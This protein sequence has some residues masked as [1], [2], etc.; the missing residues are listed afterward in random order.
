MSV[1]QTITFKERVDAFWHW[2]IEHADEMGQHIEAGMAGESSAEIESKISASFT[3][4]IDR[5]LPGFNYIFGSHPRGGYSFTLSP[6]GN[7]DLR[8]LAEY[9]L[10]QAPTIE[11][12]TFYSSRQPSLD[13]DFG[14]EIAGV[15]FDS[16]VAQF[17]LEVNEENEVIDAT[18]WHPAYVDDDDINSQVALIFLDEALGETGT[19]MWIGKI[20]LT[21]EKPDEG[22]AITA[23]ATEVVSI[24][25]MH[26]W[27]KQTPDKMHTGYSVEKPIEGHPRSDTIAGSTCH[28]SLVDQF[29]EHEGLL[30]NDPIALYGAK[31]AYLAIDSL[32]F[33]QTNEVQER[34]DIEQQLNDALIQHGSGR[35]LGGA[36]GIRHAYIDLLLV[37]GENSIE[38]IEQSMTLLNRASGYRIEPFFEPVSV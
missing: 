5:C 12:W 24:A 14:I 2:F 20:S 11:N 3:E 26:Q 7:I 10:S 6:N 32:D 16:A 25:S 27:E 13:G 23:L 18:V 38:V 15:S 22:V 21:D 31:F 9:W 36:T 8:F 33:D 19:E 4:L 30:S 17:V 34:V 29:M 35:V 28:F 1:S 37:D